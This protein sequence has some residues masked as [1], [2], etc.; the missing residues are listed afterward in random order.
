MGYTTYIQAKHSNTKYLLIRLL[1]CCLL[2]NKVFYPL[3]YKYFRLSKTS[4]D[5]PKS[6]LQ[7]PKDKYKTLVY[8]IG[9][10]HW[11]VF[12]PVFLGK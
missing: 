10:K 6:A 3:I 12:G 2:Y 1:Y 9:I 8:K 4:I 7:S 5:I 11:Q